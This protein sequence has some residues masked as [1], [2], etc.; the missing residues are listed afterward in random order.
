MLYGP[1]PAGI[2]RGES[3]GWAV[4]PL[5]ACA[6]MLVG[7]GI[8]VPAPITELLERIVEIAGR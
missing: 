5:V 4:V 6:T 8:A 7:L 2:R 3:G 1:A